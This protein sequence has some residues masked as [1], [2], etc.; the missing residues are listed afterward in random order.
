MMIQLDPSYDADNTG[1]TG[2]PQMTSESYFAFHLFNLDVIDYVTN[3]QN[4]F[5]MRQLLFFIFYFSA[6]AIRYLKYGSAT[7]FL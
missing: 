7:N 3:G 5:I 6:L 2:G 4:Q 1:H